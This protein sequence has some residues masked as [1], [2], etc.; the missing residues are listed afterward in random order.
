[1][2]APRYTTVIDPPPPN[3]RVTV[4]IITVKKTMGKPASP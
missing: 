3:K 2:N 1:M 4:D